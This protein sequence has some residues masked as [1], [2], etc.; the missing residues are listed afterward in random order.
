MINMPDTRPKTVYVRQGD[1]AV[2]GDTDVVI[3]TTLGSCVSA[4]LWDPDRGVGGLNHIILPAN[5]STDRTSAAH[6]VNAM[7]LLINDLLKLGARKSSL[8]AKIFGGSQMLSHASGIG[9]KNAEFVRA[10]LAAEGI[11]VDSSDTGGRMAREIRFW[12]T[13]GKAQQRLTSNQIREEISVPK[14]KPPEDDIEFF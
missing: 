7:E 4:C 6:G 14:P 3:A 2:S 5:P 10:F 12:P 8:R 11:P 1:L 13:S 9:L